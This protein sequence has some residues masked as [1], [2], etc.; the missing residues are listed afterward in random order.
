MAARRTWTRLR[1][2]AI[3]VPAVLVLGACNNWTQY[4]GNAAH[5]GYSSSESAIGASNV[6]TLVE[7]GT[8]ASVSGIGTISSPPTV[9]ADVL[10]A[11]SENGA[12]NGGGGG[13]LYAYSA[14]G[15]TNCS[16]TSPESC[17]PLW[18]KN[19]GGA[20]HGLSSS[21]AVDNSLSTPVVYVGGQDGVVYA[22]KAS[23]GTLLWHS[24]TLGGSIDGSLT[25]ANGY[26]YV[27]EDYG[28]V[29]VFPSTTGT[30]SND[31]NCWTDS[32]GVTECD[33]D[34]G[35]S[36]GGNNFSTPAVANG[37]LYQAAGD[38]VG[39][40]DPNDPNQYALY[41][42]NASYNASQC[43]GTFAPHLHGQSLGYIATCN[44]AWSAPW[45]QGGE[46]DGGGGSPTVA[47]GDVYIESATNGLLAF[48]ANGSGSRCTGTKYDGAVGGNLHTTLDRS[49]GR[50]SWRRRRRLDGPHSCRGER[51]R[52]YRR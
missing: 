14:D 50:R 1:R 11:T 48:S 32:Q 12:A 15:A 52:V 6:G 41:A 21:P 51:H 16:T 8:T 3:L 29:Y 24:Q 28:W 40:G 20:S 47:D 38:H 2:G 43:P 4:G 10:Y 19:P 27:P 36:T 30:D 45:Q 22:Y 25:I 18:S 34:W 49:D 39:G 42:F 9:A 7:G 31:Q 13:T 44:P 26:V 23:N 35:Y 37:M 17:T 46:W 5:T 33:P